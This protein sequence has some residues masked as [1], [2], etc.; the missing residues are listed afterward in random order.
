MN[1]LEL[2][3]NVDKNI[4]IS[5]S[6][7][8]LGLLFPLA[9][10][11]VEDAKNVNFKF[12]RIIIFTQII[13]PYKLLSSVL[14]LTFSLLLPSGY[15]LIFFIFGLGL[16]M[17]ILGNFMKWINIKGVA[18]EE[19]ETPDSYRNTLRIKFLNNLKT[20]DEAFIVWS[21]LWQ[22]PENRKDLNEE[23]LVQNFVNFYE[24]NYVESKIIG[25]PDEKFSSTDRLR[26]KE[27]LDS[28]IDKIVGEEDS[29]ISLYYYVWNKII[30]NDAL[31]R[32][33]EA[34]LF[35][36]EKC[37][38]NINSKI[39]S[40]MSH[41]FKRFIGLNITMLAATIKEFSDEDRYYFIGKFRESLEK[42]DFKY[43]IK[44][45]ENYFNVE[46]FDISSTDISSAIDKHLK[47]KSEAEL[48]QRGKDS[49]LEKEIERLLE[50]HPV[51]L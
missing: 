1:L 12:D 24:H 18:N 40:E 51:I 23:V 2:I 34:C 10:F 37:I 49:I 11:L 22:Y 14:C 43:A 32:E 19:L 20:F 38:D 4:L 36:Y 26:N 3:D 33:N 48:I 7:I 30:K 29:F 5:T 45:Y 25:I 50:K 42:V 27:K 47:Y 46:P 15:Y 41:R 13:K 8:L 35:I 44:E 21:Y 28:I 16:Y 39:N 6:G 9:I 31:V 17:Q